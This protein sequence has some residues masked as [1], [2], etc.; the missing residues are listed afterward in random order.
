MIRK[1][2]YPCENHTVYSKDGYILEMHRI[3]YG[4][5]GPSRNRS[6]VYLQH[7]FLCSSID[8]IISGPG[9]GLGMMKS[10]NIS[11]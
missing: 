6:A 7:G 4:R 1:Y 11:E 5:S 8:W 9:K 3:P 2:G 10:A